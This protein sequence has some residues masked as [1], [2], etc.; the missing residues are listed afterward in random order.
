MLI[1]GRPPLLPLA[2]FAVVDVRDIADLHLR[3]MRQPDAAGQRFLASAGQPLTL[4]EIASILRE[5]L[6][7]AGAQVPTREVPDWIVRAAARFVPALGAM[8]DLLGPPK[9]LSTAK[10]TEMLGWQPRP[11][12]DTIAATGESLLRLEMAHG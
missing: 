10:A 11:A 12:A 6:G 2:S 5:H 4:P 1:Q 3:A 7:A 8:A 9:R